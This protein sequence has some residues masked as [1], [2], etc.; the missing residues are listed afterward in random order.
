MHPLLRLTLDIFE[1]NEPLAPVDRAQAAIKN[2][3]IDGPPVF[4]H[5]RANREARLCEVL[6]AYEFKRGQRR[7]IG[8]SVG[9]DGL[10][11]S[12]PQWVALRD[13]DVALQGKAAWIV[14]KLGDAVARRQRLLVHTLAWCDGMTLPYVGAPL[15]VLLDPQR[16]S[17]P[18][19][20]APAVWMPG[21]DAASALQLALPLN[22]SPDQIRR[23]VQTWFM[24]DATRL[25]TERLNHFAPQLQVQWRQLALSNA[26]TRWGSARN[27]GAIR[28]NWR[29]MHFRLPVIDYVVAH[30]LSHLREM[31]HSPRFWDTVRS[32]VPDYAALRQ[33][34]KDQAVPRW[35]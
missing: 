8:F 14:R 32:V 33:Q 31:N 20:A 4:R 12:A 19:G 28:L 23:A 15:Q 1:Q 13:V 6:V 25:F 34:L 26:A 7:T 11:V 17:V 5:P 24:R 18:R 9:P 27:D 22:A 2:V 30:E 3:A 29:L 35:A 21:G 16:T 10:V